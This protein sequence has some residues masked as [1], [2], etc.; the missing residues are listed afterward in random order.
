MD[1][2][3]PPKMTLHPLPQK[4]GAFVSKLGL[5]FILKKQPTVNGGLLFC[6]KV[7]LLG[8]ILLAKFYKRMKKDLHVIGCCAQCYH[9]PL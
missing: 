3:A 7:L 2:N 9:L 8:H 5:V 1:L 6:F 4:V